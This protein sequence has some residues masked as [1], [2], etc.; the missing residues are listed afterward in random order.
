M[1]GKSLSRTDSSFGVSPAAFLSRVKQL[2]PRVVNTV[3][4]MF[5]GAFV[6]RGALYLGY[7]RDVPLVAGVG[8]ALTS[9]LLFPEIAMALYTEELV[10]GFIVGDLYGEVLMIAS[11]ILQQS[12]LRL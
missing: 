3:I 1:F 7:S 6:Y 8:A 2:S 10:T 4:S 9:F 12:G 5:A 11:W